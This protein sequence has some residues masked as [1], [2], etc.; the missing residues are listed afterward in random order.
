MLSSEFVGRIRS[1]AANPDGRT[2]APDRSPETGFFGG[3]FKTVRVPLGDAPAPAP[4]P[5]PATADDIAAAQA[6]LGFGLPDDLKQLYTEI[7]NGGFGPGDGLASLNEVARRYRELT[8][9][10]PGEQGQKWP[11]RLLPFILTVPGADCYDLETGQIVLWDEE[12]LADGAQWEQSFR[13]DAESLTAWLEAWLARP[14]LAE[15]QE[16]GMEEALL[17]NM[18]T[19]LAYWRAKSVE[20]RA[21][22][23]LPEE[24]WEEELFGHLGIDLTKL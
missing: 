6:R 21:E 17:E 14:P 20:E 19:T 5:P 11:E 7:A 1:R 22:F 16:Q 13:K 8:A 2:D 18:K 9:S 23:G 12:L 3:A 15:Q 4:L 24:G 10:P